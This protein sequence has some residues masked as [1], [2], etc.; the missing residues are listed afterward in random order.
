MSSNPDLASRSFVVTTT[1]VGFLS[2]AD[3]RMVCSPFRLKLQALTMSLINSESGCFLS[4]RDFWAMF[5]LKVD[6]SKLS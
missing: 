3:S 5:H 6:R 1:R 2:I 4:K